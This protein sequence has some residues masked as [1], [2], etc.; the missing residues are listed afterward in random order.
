MSDRS[1]ELLNHYQQTVQPILDEV[2]GVTG[3]PSHVLQPHPLL[4]VIS[5]PSGV[6]KDSVLQRMKEREVPF[7]FVVTAT[8]RPRRPNEVHGRDY[9]FVSTDVFETM[10]R[11]NEMLEHAVVYDHY[12]GIPK[13]QVRDAFRSG[14]D[15]VL[16]IDVQGAETIKRLVPDALL[17]FLAASDLTELM[18][19]LIARKTETAADLA[20]RMATAQAEMKKVDLFDYVVINREDALGETVDQVLSIIKA[21]KSRVD[22]TPVVL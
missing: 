5:G 2:D 7:H 20:K 9:L 21:E 1:V 16:R 6:G 10:I 18:E 13:Q 14:L 3:L 8:D 17:I 4:I 11:A 15:V 12:K 22:W 19:R